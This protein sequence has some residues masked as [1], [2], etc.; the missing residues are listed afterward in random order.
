MGKYF[1]DKPRGKF[2][3]NEPPEKAIAVGTIKMYKS[4]LN[5]QRDKEV[6]WYACFN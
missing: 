3:W 5:R 2:I 1:K 4:D 6:D